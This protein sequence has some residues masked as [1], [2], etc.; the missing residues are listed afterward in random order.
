MAGYTKLF[1]SIVSSTV[2]CEDDQT[3]RVWIWMLAT[4]DTDGHVEGSIPALARITNYSIQEVEHAIARLSSPDAYSRTKE[5]EGRRIEEIPGGWR[6]LNFPR[7]REQTQGKEGSRAPYFRGYRKRQKEKTE[8]SQSESRTCCAQHSG[9]ARNTATATATATEARAFSGETPPQRPRAIEVPPA[10]APGGAEK[11][12]KTKTAPG[13]P[14]W[15]AR[16]LAALEVGP[17][18]QADLHRR[19]GTLGLRAALVAMARMKT[20]AKRPGAL[21]T[22]KGAELAAE[23]KA[24]LAQALEAAL[25]GAGGA[26]RDARW[27]SMPED[28][29]HDPEIQAAWAVHRAAQAHVEARRL[30]TRPDAFETPGYDRWQYALDAAK[31]PRAQLVALLQA[32]ASPA[33]P[34]GLV[35]G[36]VLQHFGLADGPQLVKAGTG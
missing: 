1:S 25:K 3:F 35:N 12:G 4:A 15:L 20:P 26:L 23:G 14:A 28:L 36:A 31:A 19:L 33:M 18:D 5:H 16:D 27:L 17:R 32:R 21:L 29:R 10:A 22:A 7:Y 24:F 9:V 34:A 8:N 11:P 6:I 13:L 30:E 2:W